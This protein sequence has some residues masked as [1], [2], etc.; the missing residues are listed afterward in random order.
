[1]P[2]PHEV[3]VG[4]AALPP[5]RSVREH[6]REM[7][8]TSSGIP[9][10]EMIDRRSNGGMRAP[11]TKSANE[12]VP[13]A[14]PNRT[15]HVHGAKYASEIGPMLYRLASAITP[16]PNAAF[17]RNKVTATPAESARASSV[18]RTPSVKRVAPSGRTTYATVHARTKAATPI[19]AA[20]ARRTNAL[21]CERA[22][23]GSDQMTKP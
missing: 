14:I 20:V 8:A 3:P 6:R 17:H 4:D 9:A 15:S 12:F 22:L 7:Y 5:Q 18:G 13:S 21:R 16:K 2:D 1:M 10:W 23:R 19:V 11:G